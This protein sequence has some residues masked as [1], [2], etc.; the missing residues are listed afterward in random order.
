MDGFR[1]DAVAS[2]LY[3]DYGKRDGEWIANKNGSNENLDAVE[4]LQQMNK[5]AFSYDSSVLMIAEESTAWPL[6]TQPPENGGLG[7]N[8]KWNMGW[9]NDML[10]YMQTNPY[11]RKNKHNNLTFSLTYAFS[12][13][14]ILPLSHDEVVHGKYSMINKMPGEYEEKFANLRAFY[15]YMMAHPGKKL[16]FMGNEF[17]QFIEW[18]FAKGL[19]FNLLDFDYHKA[20]SNYVSDL[21]HF[22]LENKSLWENDSGWDGFEWISNDDYEQNIIAFRRIDRKNNE[23]ICICNF[24]GIKR[25]NYKIGVPYFA[26]YSECFSS[27]DEKYM[28]SGVHNVNVKSAREPMHSYNYSI[29]LS[30][31]A[32]STIYLKADEIYQD[33]ELI[34]D[35]KP[36]KQEKINLKKA[37]LIEKKELTGGI[38]Q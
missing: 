18:D 8:F 11:F 30:I 7:F 24:S 9:M 5:A 17:A 27:D 1:V 19:D 23:I 36:V 35:I 26:K 22:Y 2:M 10:D 14:Y 38:L 32:Q 20:M 33:K 21:N 31:P 15:A 16:S 12:E 6:V 37:F 25:L 4:F 13:N 3:L 29:S 28:G 34:S